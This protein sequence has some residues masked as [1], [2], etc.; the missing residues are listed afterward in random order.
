[1]PSR[2]A[3]WLAGPFTAVRA[4]LSAGMAGEHGITESGGA[5]EGAGEV[6][7][8][9]DRFSQASVGI[10]PGGRGRWK[11][12]W[13]WLG[14]ALGEGALQCVPQFLNPDRGGAFNQQNVDKVLRPGAGL[15]GFSVG[16]CVGAQRSGAAASRRRRNSSKATRL[17]RRA[18][19]IPVSADSFFRR[20]SSAW[21]NATALVYFMRASR[22]GKWPQACAACGGVWL[23]LG[24]DRL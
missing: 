4:P 13:Q 22:Q 7:L 12:R 19:L 18:R 1:M 2:L 24:V 3:A 11:A 23:P 14:G 5:C 17:R 9:V 8:D 6:C 21:R 15:F 20:C 16:S 10:G